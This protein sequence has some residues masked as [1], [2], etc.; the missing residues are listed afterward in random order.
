MARYI[1]LSGA[2]ADLGNAMKSSIC[3][4]CRGA[5][6]QE[7]QEVQDVQEVQKGQEVQEV[8]KC[9]RAEVQK[10]RTFPIWV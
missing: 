5:E 7:V 1:Y 4:K 2:M 9:R 6:V 8:Q 3:R 10:A